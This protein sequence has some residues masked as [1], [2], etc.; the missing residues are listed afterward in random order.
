[1]RNFHL[2]DRS[3]VFSKSGMVA[4][5]H[6]IAS[7]VGMTVLK[8]GGNAADAAL[9]MALVLPICE[10]QSTGLFGDSFA[11][12]KKSGSNDIIGI[13]GSG[14][15]PKAFSADKLREAGYST[16]PK[17]EALSVTMPGA[18]SAFELIAND[19]SKWG[20]S[21]ACKPA[22]KYSE[23]GVPIHPRVALDWNLEGSNLSGVAQQFY[24]LNGKIPKTGQIFR[25]PMQGEVL[26]YISDHGAKGFYDGVVAKDFISSLKELGGPHDYEDLYEVTAEYVAPISET[27]RGYE[28]VELPPNGQG[29]TALLML[30]LLERFDLS[31]MDPEGAERIHLEAEISKLA[32]SAR[33]KIIGDPKIEDID[34][35]SFYSQLFVSQLLDSIDIER[36]NEHN[37]ITSH[38]P[39]KDTVYLTAIDSEGMAVSLIF[40]IFDSFGT[41]LASQRYGIL[42]QNRGS[43]FTLEPGHPNEAKAG[44]RPL[45]TIIPGMLKKDG[46][47]FMTFGVMGGQ[48]QAN[49]HARVISNL[50]DFNMDVQEA[51]SF[52]RSFANEGVLQLEHGYSGKIEKI[53]SS[54]GHNVVR[55]DKPIGGGQ[56][57]RRDPASG[58]LI[59][60]SDPR[61]DGCA[62]GF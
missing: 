29:A 20:L 11:L 49:G 26:R 59:G 31:S 15:A 53:L 55:P 47:F 5:S 10:P 24:L 2:P 52:P 7:S 40:S 30:K 14:K 39:H 17:N 8:N 60:G 48:Y 34:V 41:G 9:A 6:P 57:I 54:L 27:Y 56:V 13:N 46:N 25:A 36:V 44:K 62:L 51:L 22:I 61:K 43:G 28:V 21:E 12:V 45:H 50:I 38:N 37:L 4:T 58:L 3:P 33:D 23:E 19:F 35:E 42:F 18:V 32:Y 16:M 1:M